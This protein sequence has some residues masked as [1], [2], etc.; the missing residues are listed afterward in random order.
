[1]K[2]RAVLPELWEWMTIRDL[3][4]PDS[5]AIVD[6]PFGS[7]LKT[8]D[9]VKEGVPVLQGSNITGNKF[10]FK[11][12]RY[13]SSK[14]ARE[15]RRSFV[16][17]GDLLVVK[18]GSIGYAAIIDDLEDYEF[19]LIPANLLK[20]TFDQSKAD[21]R[22][23]LH[24]LTSELGTRMLVE[25]AGRTAQPA[26]SLGKFKNLEI[27]TPPHQE[28]CRIAEILDTIDEAIHKTELLIAKL[29]AMKQGLLHDLLTRGLD[30]NGKLRNPQAHPEQFKDSP[31]GKIPKDWT[32]PIFKEITPADAP[33]CYGIVQPG[34]Y[35]ESG[36]PVVAINNLNGD[37]L[38][39]H[40]SARVIEQSYTRSRIQR[41][42]VLLSIKG[43]TGRADIVPNW[44]LGNISRD[45]ARIRPKSAVSPSY[46]KQMLLWDSYQR[47]LENAVVGTTRSEISIG[48]LRKLNLPLPEIAEQNKISKA[49]E[50]Y[51]SLIH[52]EE[53]HLAKLKLQK[54]GLMHDLLTGK[55]RVKIGESKG[56]VS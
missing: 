17:P 45:L 31:L 53:Q 36:V 3:A 8:A 52:A 37:Y 34:P 35:D 55:V 32:T 46:L 23:I 2:I 16:R 40:R 6:G 10:S 11:D 43:S 51:D 18:I 44:F 25:L 24:F 19:A 56:A 49:A 5:N 14:K 20:A 41:G 9:Y 28:Q 1:M 21:T 54:K 22:Y 15:L 38:N 7:N 42:D 4:A 50:S 13:V 26:L 47:Y 30:E 48:I 39:V 29:K 12:I 27:P 33:I